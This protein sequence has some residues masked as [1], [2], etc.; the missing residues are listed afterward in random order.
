M[1]ENIILNDNDNIMPLSKDDKNEKLIEVSHDEND[2]EKIIK[3]SSGCCVNFINTIFPC[4]K[5]VDIESSRIVYF[6]KSYKNITNWSNKEENHKYSALLFVPIV[7]FNQFRQFGNFFYL[8][9]SISQLIPQ[10]VV[11]F[12]FTYVSPLCMVVFFSM[13]KEL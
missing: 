1:K 6:R 3:K 11:G 12:L 5:K 9:L 8:L 13:F 2:D 4:F 10:F 7:L